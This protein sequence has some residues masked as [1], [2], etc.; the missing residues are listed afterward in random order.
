MTFFLGRKVMEKYIRS[1]TALNN[2][3]LN[4]K[5]ADDI[6]RCAESDI[7]WAQNKNKPL[8]ERKI[9]KGNIYQFEFGKNYVP[10]MSYEHRGLVIGISGKLLYVLPICSFN[11]S[12]K[13][14]TSAYHPVDNLNTKSN[15]YLLKQCEHSFLTHDSV[16]KLNDIRT[17]S[18]A[19]IKY[20]QDNGYLDPQST[21]Y[22]E[23]EKIVFSKYFYKYSYDYN[24]LTEEN[25]KLNEE[26]A[27]LNALNSELQEQVNS[28]RSVCKEEPSE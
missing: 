11:S 22:K 7:F 13:E 5:N 3:T 20:K 9:K 28:L 10:E 15:Y 8:L 6:E 26:I 1:I 4:N 17:V 14:H 16:L 18:I 24:K 25:E 21:T 12:K 23:I 2:A 27:K 19:R